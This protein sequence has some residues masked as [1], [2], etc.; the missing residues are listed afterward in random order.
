MVFHRQ[1][2]NCQNSSQQY[3]SPNQLKYT[4]QVVESVLDN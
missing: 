2:N 4:G 1:T 3:S